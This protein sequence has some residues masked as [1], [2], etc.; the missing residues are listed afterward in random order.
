MDDVAKIIFFWL[1]VHGMGR[2]VKVAWQ[3]LDLKPG[4][5]R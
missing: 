5:K 1:D 2:Q 3:L 4:V